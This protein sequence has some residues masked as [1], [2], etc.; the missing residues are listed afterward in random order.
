MGRA[1]DSAAPGST[2]VGA[3]ADLARQL[4][5]GDPERLA[6]S[7]AVAERAELLAVTVDAGDREV[8]VAAAWLHDI[9]YS[10]GVQQT[11]FHP[12]DGAR[13]LRR[14]GWPQQVQ[15]LVAHHSGSRFVAAV[16]TLEPSLAEFTFSE[17]E[18]SDA[19]TVADQTVGPGGRLM[20]VEERIADMLERHGPSSPNALAH[21]RRQPYLVEA[22]RRVAARLADR[23]EAPQ[24]H[25]LLISASP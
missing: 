25:R 14:S 22:V 10:L 4:L 8:L 20:P 6:H 17:D 16:R 15:D 9:G 13:H 19:L 7:A 1:D 12:V 3:A 21:S 18:L 5:S 23:G 24:Q 2:L 11:G